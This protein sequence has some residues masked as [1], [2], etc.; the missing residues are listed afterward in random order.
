LNTPVAAVR[1][2]PTG[3]IPDRLLANS[4]NNDGCDR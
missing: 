4:A 2:A 3:L 1:S